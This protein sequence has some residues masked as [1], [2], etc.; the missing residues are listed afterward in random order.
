V[1]LEKCACSVA[2]FIGFWDV[3]YLEK[4]QKK[5]AILIYPDQIV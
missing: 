1:E 2:N 3:L 5:K 4:R